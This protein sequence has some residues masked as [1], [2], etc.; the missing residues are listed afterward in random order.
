[1]VLKNLSFLV[2]T[3]VGTDVLLGDGQVGTISLDVGQ[4]LVDRG[5]ELWDAIH[6]VTQLSIP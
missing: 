5:Q 3:N 1:M 2:T 4:S 6:L